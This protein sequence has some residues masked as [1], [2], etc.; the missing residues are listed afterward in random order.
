MKTAVLVCGQYRQFEQAYKSWKFLEQLD[1]DV[2]VSTW[3]K[4]KQLYDV[5]KYIEFDVNEEM[6][7]TKIKT[8]LIDIVDEKNY[9]DFNNSEKMVFHSKNCLKNVLNSNFEY[10]FFL[11][12]RMDLYVENTNINQYYLFYS[13]NKK[14]KI[15]GDGCGLVYGENNEPLFNN[16]TFF[17]GK[18]ESIIKL[19]DALPNTI[20]NAHADFGE[21]F[22]KTELEFEQINFFR[23]QFIRPNILEENLNVDLINNKNNEY[24]E[25]V[26]NKH[27]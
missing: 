5:G 18:T 6:I 23:S 3:N 24:V 11:Y 19:I 13:F 17:F 10:D 27:Y 12:I 22:V 8:K 21:T 25:F 14:N 9:E 2:F 16:D 1:C 26:R 20:K 4:S 7:S 15:Y